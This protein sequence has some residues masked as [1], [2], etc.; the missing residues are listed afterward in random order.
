MVAELVAFRKENEQ[1]CVY[2]DR[3]TVIYSFSLL[4]IL[5]TNCREDDDDADTKKE[6]TR[7]R[8]VAFECKISCISN[9]LCIIVPSDN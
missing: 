2:F 7:S 8:I 5:S 9:I 1:C 4:K 6:A 3:S